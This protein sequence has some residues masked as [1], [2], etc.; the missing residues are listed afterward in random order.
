MILCVS[1]GQK[2]VEV[3]C[4]SQLKC[5][6]VLGYYAGFNTTVVVLESEHLEVDELVEQQ[7]DYSTGSPMMVPH[8]MQYTQV[9]VATGNEIN[10]SVSH[11]YYTCFV[12]TLWPFKK[13]NVM[14]RTYLSCLVYSYVPFF[15]IK[16]NFLL[17]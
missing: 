6:R 15:S 3:C 2:L 1:L 14:V 5:T 8:T 16:P 11:T 4:I 13:H 9:I 7:V 17:T 12:V 10:H